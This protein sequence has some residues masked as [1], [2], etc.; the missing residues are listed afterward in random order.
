MIMMY[1]Y[2]SSVLISAVLDA[3][4]FDEAGLRKSDIGNGTNLLS[5]DGDRLYISVADSRGKPVPNHH[6]G[7]LAGTRDNT[8][9]P[10]SVHRP[11]NGVSRVDYGGRDVDWK[12]DVTRMPNGDSGTSILLPSLLLTAITKLGVER[13]QACTR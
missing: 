8:A 12:Y 6:D 3:V 2:R 7:H 11:Q 1:C 5:C 9:L 10:M 4:C 13:V